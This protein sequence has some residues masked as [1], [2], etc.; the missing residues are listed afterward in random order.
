MIQSRNIELLIYNIV[1]VFLEANSPDLDNMLGYCFRVAT[2]SILYSSSPQPLR[3][4]ARLGG[5]RGTGLP[6]R[7]AGTHV[8][9]VLVRV[10]DWYTCVSARQLGTRAS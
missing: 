7:R 4:A 1:T 6:E 2:T 10:A 5:E 3:L 8:H 9:V